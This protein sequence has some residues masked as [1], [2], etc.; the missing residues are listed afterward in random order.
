MKYSL[1]LLFAFLFIL[2]PLVSATTNNVQMNYPFD[3]DFKDVTANH[4]DLTQADNGNPPPGIN[5]TTFKIGNASLSI[6]N[7]GLVDSHFL[8]PSEQSIAVWVNRT[9]GASRYPIVSYARCPTFLVCSVDSDRWIFEILG[10]GTLAVDIRNGS[11]SMTW[12]AVAPVISVD[13]WNHVGVTMIDGHAPTFYINGVAF[14]ATNVS[15][16]I[17]PAAFITGEDRYFYVGAD[18]ATSDVFVR[19]LDELS[20]WFKILTNNDFLA[21][22]NA[23]A[24]LEYPYSIA[25]DQNFT[26]SWNSSQSLAVTTKITMAQNSSDFSYK[27]ALSCDIFTSTLWNEVF[28]TFYNFTRSNASPNFPNPESY[29]TFNGIQWNNTV[30]VTQNFDIVKNA[31]L[32]YRDYLSLLF[33]YQTN[34]D[35]YIDFISYDDSLNPALYLI[36]NKTGNTLYVRQFNPNFGIST[37]VAN[38]SLSGGN[39]NLMIAL[40]PHHDFGTNLDDFTFTIQ[41]SNHTGSQSSASYGT[42]SGVSNI[43]N[44]EVFSGNRFNG[45]TFYKRLSLSRTNNPMPVFTEFQNGQRYNVNGTIVENPPPESSTAGDGFIVQPDFNNVFYSVCQY[46]TLGTYTQRHFI[47]PTGSADNYGNFRDLVITAQQV[48]TNSSLDNEGGNA[49]NGSG[50]FGTD[51]LPSFLESIGFKSAASKLFVW[52]IFSLLIAALAFKIHPILGVLV[53][54]GLLIVGV[55]FHVVPTWFLIMFGILAAGITALLLKYAFGSG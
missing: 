46:S 39:V 20:V 9:S 14:S 32:G 22:Y 52:F 42:I 8:V 31:N 12:G 24:G 17:D 37:D 36:L 7:N 16:P 3:G 6:F 2:V 21:M 11:D 54:I 28:N 29:L 49:G 27:Y 4:H 40:T 15:G 50:D 43:K 33:Q 23:G 51:F 13:Q 34:Q 30:G 38:F 18:R 25:S 35:S 1:A 26:V 53:F 41:E 44:V 5:G 55:G 48:S 19:N 10:N 47:S 45:T